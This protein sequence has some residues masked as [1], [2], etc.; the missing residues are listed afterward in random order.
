MEIINIKKSYGNQLPSQ[1]R[2]HVGFYYDDYY[3]DTDNF[4]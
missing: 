2:R 1:L 4:C 3:G